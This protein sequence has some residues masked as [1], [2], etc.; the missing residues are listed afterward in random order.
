M[1]LNPKILIY[2]FEP[3]GK[4]RSNTSAR[5]LAALPDHSDWYKAVLPVRFEA[6]IFL[7]FAQSV[8]ADYILG[9]GQCP[10]GKLIRIERKAF[11]WMGDRSS[12]LNQAIDDGPDSISCN[13]RI[14]VTSQR[15]DSYDAGRYVCN[16]SMYV[17]NRYAQAHG[18]KYAFLHIPKDYSVTG[19]AR[20][21]QTIL[22]T[23]V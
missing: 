7:D 10:R 4:Y 2:A 18:K 9:L 23:M 12:D 5:V 11:N 8:D 21:I 20:Q 22:R 19:A 13:W 17:L 3:F 15:R 14:P 6:P 1:P 16:Y